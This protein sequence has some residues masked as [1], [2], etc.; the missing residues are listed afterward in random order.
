MATTRD[1]SRTFFLWGNLLPLAK[2]LVT[3]TEECMWRGI[4]AVKPGGRIGDIGAAIQAYA[5]AEG[6]SVV[7]DFVGPWSPPHFFIRH[8]KFP[9][10]GGG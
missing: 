8:L 2:K 3:V 5:E 9:T 10:T 1:T 7:R 6:F 4:N